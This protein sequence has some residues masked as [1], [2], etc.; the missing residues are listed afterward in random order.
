MAHIT[1]EQLITYQTIIE[2][3]VDEH[4]VN[5]IKEYSELHG[6]ALT[7]EDIHVIRETIAQGE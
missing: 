5:T 2:N 4:D 3:G 1:E 6:V 7:E